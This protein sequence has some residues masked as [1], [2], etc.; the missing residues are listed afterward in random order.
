MQILTEPYFK[1]HIY[2][3]IL[4]FDNYP[5]YLLLLAVGLS[6]KSYRKIFFWGFIGAMLAKLFGSTLQAI[7]KIKLINSPQLD[8]GC[9]SGHLTLATFIYL[10]LAK[11]DVLFIR[12]FFFIL[13]P[14]L[15][16]ATVQ[17]GYHTSFDV[18]CGILAGSVFYFL[19][20]YIYQQPLDLRKKLIICFWATT[21]IF[22]YTT[23][24][25]K[26]KIIIISI[27][28]PLSIFIQPYLKF[29]REKEI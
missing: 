20:L 10:W 3:F 19:Y 14:L 6:L 25:F 9:P 11:Y 26:S 22:L 27:L 21:T 4:L 24:L 23:I 13:I 1:E 12:K 7:F 2:P 29:A 8:Y 16:F 17:V 5:F 28:L 15:A 18:V